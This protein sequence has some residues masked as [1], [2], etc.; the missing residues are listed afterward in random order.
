MF[1]TLV[2]T[3]PQGA[4][5]IPARLKATCYFY[6]ICAS[7]TGE[8]NTEDRNVTRWT[9]GWVLQREGGGGH[10]QMLPQRANV[11]AHRYCVDEVTKGRAGQLDLLTMPKH[12]VPWTPSGVPSNAYFDEEGNLIH[13]KCEVCGAPAGFGAEVST[14]DGYLGRWFCREHRP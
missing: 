1:L 12:Q 3:Y 2:P 5:M 9:S 10:S 11:Y 4:D 8:L 13:D 6:G 14:K 7:C